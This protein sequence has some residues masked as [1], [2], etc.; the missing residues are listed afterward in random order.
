MYAKDEHFKD[1]NL[2][3]NTSIMITEVDER[4]TKRWTD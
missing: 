1:L 2:F 4:L 3:T